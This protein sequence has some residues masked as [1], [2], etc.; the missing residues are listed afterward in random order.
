M[1][2]CRIV[3]SFLIQEVNFNNSVR[4]LNFLLGVKESETYTFADEFFTRK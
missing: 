4:D 2:G 3:S 1:H